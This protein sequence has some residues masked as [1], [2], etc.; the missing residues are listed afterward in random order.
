MHDSRTCTHCHQTKP[1]D[2]FGII[3]D[4]RCRSPR[5][6]PMCKACNVKKAAAWQKENPERAAAN[7]AKWRK[8]KRSSWL[9]SA[10]AAT[11]KR[12]SAKYAQTPPWADLAKI[13]DI[14]ELAAALRAEG[15]DVVVDH[16]VPLQGKT[17]S[18]L[19]THHNLQIIERR[20]NS[21]KRDRVP[22]DPYAIPNALQQYA[23]AGL[24]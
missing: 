12:L 10:Y 4:K 5:R 15:M 14:Y 11:A 6:N 19:H 18:G 24:I 17:A 13:A 20:E 2:A 1:V 16:I 22:A 21:R 7:Q 9:R 23:G 3:N 8:E